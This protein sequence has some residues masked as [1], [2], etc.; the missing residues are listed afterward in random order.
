VNTAISS[1]IGGG[2]NHSS[3]QTGDR[4]Q[5]TAQ[6]VIAENVKF[7]VEQLEQGNSETLTVYLAA[8]ARFHNYS[9]G[10]ILSIARN[11]P[12]ATHVAGIRTWN[13]LG[14]FVVKGQKGIPILAPLI[15]HK[16]QPNE[17]IKE[18]DEK[19]KPFVL[20]FRRV[21]V[22]DISQ[23]EGA[24]LPEPARVSGEV[25]F[26]RARL[27]EFVEQQGIILEF[28]ERIAP[29]Q[30]A[31]YGGKI[32]LLPGQ[33]EAEEFATLVHEVAHELLHRAERRTMTTKTVRETEAEAIAFIVSRAVGLNT[34]SASADYIS[35]YHGNAE[36]LT[37]SLSVIQQASS[38]IL[39]AL[40]IEEQEDV[41][42]KAS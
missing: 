36:L 18:S 4:Q 7:L 10:N 21:F 15:G 37:E 8:M 28:N 5:H 26:H 14:R 39:A 1:T 30:G 27:F 11:R 40:F 22:F 9:F 33:S 25:G 34:G 3:Q 20:G 38:A 12:D 13:E 16:R 17:Q 32:V 42:A 29:A 41:L 2:A 35:L 6:N 19:P 31:S 23:T 24:D